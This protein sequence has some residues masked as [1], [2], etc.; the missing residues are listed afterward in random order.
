MSLL[1]FGN[2]SPPCLYQDV[3]TFCLACGCPHFPVR[4]EYFN[5]QSM[6]DEYASAFDVQHSL[7]S[8]HGIGGMKSLDWYFN[9][10]QKEINEFFRSVIPK[11]YHWTSKSVGFWMQQLVIVDIHG[12]EYPNF[13]ADIEELRYLKWNGKGNKPL[14]SDVTARCKSSLVSFRIGTESRIGVV[15]HQVCYELWKNNFQKLPHWWSAV[16]NRNQPLNIV[17]ADLKMF[18]PPEFFSIYQL[19]DQAWYFTYPKC[20]IP[21]KKYAVVDQKD[22]KRSRFKRACTSRL[23]SSSIVSELDKA[24]NLVLL[25]NTLDV[26]D[27]TWCAR[28][29]NS[30]FVATSYP[31]VWKNLLVRHSTYS[32]VTK[33]FK[34]DYAIDWKI[35]YQSLESEKNRELRN[36]FRIQSRWSEI[37]KSFTSV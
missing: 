4:Y 16:F 1:T 19:L 5:V 30:W 28:V 20:K 34:Y 24:F 32:Y 15:F 11:K 3:V 10:S 9:A 29:C 26:C 25:S 21:W 6:F 13:I 17:V 2:A 36:F 7:P 12:N 18:Y 27:L 33:V 37:E 22:T 8:P 14:I 31:I 23:E 35:V